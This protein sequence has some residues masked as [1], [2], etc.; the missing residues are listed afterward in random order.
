MLNWRK[1]HILGYRFYLGTLVTNKLSD[2]GGWH[3]LHLDCWC[4]VIILLV[5]KKTSSYRKSV[6]HGHF[7]KHRPM[8]VTWR[9][10]F[11][12]WTFL[13]LSVAFVNGWPRL[14][15]ASA[16]C[17]CQCL[18]GKISHICI[19]AF[20]LP[21]FCYCSQRRLTAHR[22]WSVCSVLF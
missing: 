19:L 6:L 15:I 5:W 4:S 7:P 3:S 8:H 2:F 9:I 16:D 20:Y 1:D 21:A 11:F 12:F 14:I 13:P 22:I 10:S 17:I 18:S